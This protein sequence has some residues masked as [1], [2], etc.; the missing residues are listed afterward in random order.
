MAAPHTFYLEQAENCGKAADKAILPNE[1]EKFLRAQ[2]S[3]E[4]LAN[5]SAK[6]LADRAEREAQSE[7]A[8]SEL[9]QSQLS[10]SQLS[11]SEH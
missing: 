4:A 9:A 5:K 2:A 7:L 6:A 3:W 10:Q 8:R 11:Q 1:R